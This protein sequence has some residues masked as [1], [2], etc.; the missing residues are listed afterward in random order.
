MAEWYVCDLLCDV[1]WFVGLRLLC[2]SVCVLFFMCMLLVMYDVMVCGLSIC[3]VFVCCV[4]VCCVV[5]LMCLHA[6]L[7][8][9][10]VLYG[11]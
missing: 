3:L 4:A 9:Y 11:C 8:I 6:V 5:C 2:L 10:S 1:V 7:G